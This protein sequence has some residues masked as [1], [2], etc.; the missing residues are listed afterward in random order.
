MKITNLIIISF[1]FLITCQ[2]QKVPNEIT[3]EGQVK[4]IPKGKIYLYEARSRQIPLDSTDCIKGHFVFNIKT[5]PSFIPYMASIRIADSISPTKFTP[6][7]I[8]NDFLL[9]SDTTKFYNYGYDAFYLEKGKTVIT[10]R[11]RV[12][13]KMPRLILVSI[14]AGKETE[15]LYRNQFTDFGWLGN[16]DSTKRRPSKNYFFQKRNTKASF[17]LFS[18]SRHL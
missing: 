16:A 13:Q 5:D 8:A 3:I 7:I 18:S 1:F 4:N 15:L 12:K 11:E 2:D 10:D 6:L 9:P 17:F 14:K